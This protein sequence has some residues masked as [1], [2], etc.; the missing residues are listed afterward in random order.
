MIRILSVQKDQ[1][2]VLLGTDH[3]FVLL[4]DDGGSPRGAHF[5]QRSR[6]LCLVLKSFFFKLARPFKYHI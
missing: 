1:I 5:V 6:V 2:S 3:S 4:Y